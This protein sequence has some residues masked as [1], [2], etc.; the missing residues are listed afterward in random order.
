MS[1][2][3]PVA[4]AD[5]VRRYARTLVRRHPRALV[6]ALG[7]H[8]LGAAAGLVAP[9]LLGDLVEG[10][11]RGVSTVTVDRVALAIAGFVVAQAVLVRLAHLASARL[12]ERVLAELR[13]EFVDRVLALPLST[14]ERAG[15]GDL[16]TRTSRDVAALS[17]TV[18]FAMPETLIAAVTVVLIVGAL[19]VTGPLLALPCLLAVPVLWAGTRWYLRRA[20]AGYLRENAAYSDIT[21]GISEAVE[22]ARTTEALRQQA[23][24]RARGDA[25]IRRSYAAERYTLNLRTV[26]FPVAEIGY[27]LPVTATLLIGGW[28]HLRGWVSLGQVTAATLYVQQLVDPIDRLLSWLDELQVGGASMARLLGVSA[29]DPVPPAPAGAAPADGDRRVAAHDVRYAYRDGHDVLHGVT[30]VPRPGETLA[31]VGPSGA[32]KSTLGRLLAGVHA[33]RSGSVTVDGRQLAGLPLAELRT[34][35]ALVSQEH[36]VFIGTLAENVAM[37][38]PDADD[39][40]VRSALAA[41][42]ALD[43]AQALPDG[44]RTVV[45]AG[46]HPLSPAQA[47]QLALARLVLA[48]PHTLVL[49]EATSLIDPRAARALERSLAAVLRGRTVIAIAHRLFSAHDADRV[50]VVEDGR[51]AELGSHD[52][53]VAADGSYAALWR[54]WHG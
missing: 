1:T 7:L 6:G 12:G 47:Q 22:G 23:R 39:A 18:R 11:S 10:I 5:Q 54:S 34:H 20:P 41:V 8:A 33:P 48:D 21:D 35:V 2:A 9:R 45:G 24:R 40:A 14:V 42:D 49:D 4:D 53:L 29:A 15:T 36:H 16:L 37:V 30:L 28:F 44:V 52:E 32:G 46:G 27:V 3:L 43:W 25:D 19:L 17:K 31:M 50:A 26:F 38:R 13:E 51:I